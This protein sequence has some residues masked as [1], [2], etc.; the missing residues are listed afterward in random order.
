MVLV[1]GGVLLLW[2]FDMGLVGMRHQI[3]EWEQEDPHQVDEVP[4]EADEFGRNVVD[5]DRF[6]SC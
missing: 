2:R 1:S 4:V 5:H 6:G 3:E